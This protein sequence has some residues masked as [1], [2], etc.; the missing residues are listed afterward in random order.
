VRERP[1]TA[2]LFDALIEEDA[3]EVAR[4]H[5]SFPRHPKAELVGR[6]L[7]TRG[8]EG[9]RPPTVDEVM[10]AHGILDLEA[11]LLSVQKQLSVTQRGLDEAWG[12]ANRAETVANAYAAVMVL[13]VMLT[14]LGW[15]AALGVVPLFPAPEATTKPAH[16][17]STPTPEGGRNTGGDRSETR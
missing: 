14:V 16:P 2:E 17:S 8:V 15:A 7:A 10:A 11:H 4:V 1:G 13:L 3:E 6:W 12:R 9:P 5:G